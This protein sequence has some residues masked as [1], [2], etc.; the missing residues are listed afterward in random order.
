ETVAH[1]NSTINES[2]SI[3]AYNLST[4]I[5]IENVDDVNITKYWIYGGDENMNRLIVYLNATFCN[6]DESAEAAIPPE[7]VLN[8]AIISS[9]DHIVSGIGNA[10]Q[11]D[12]ILNETM[13]VKTYFAKSYPNVT[14]P[15]DLDLSDQDVIFVNHVSQ[16]AVEHINNAVHAAKGNGAYVITTEFGDALNF[17]NVNLTDHPYIDQYINNPGPEN[18]R[19]FLVYLGNRFGGFDG[20]IEQPILISNFAIYHPDSGAIFEDRDEY[21]DW[22]RNNTA[23]YRYDPG[24]PTIG[25]VFHKNHYV[26]HDLKVEDMLIRKTEEQDCNVIP[27]FCSHQYNFK[28]FFM[29]DGVTIVD[30]IIT[31]NYRMNWANFTE[32]VEDAKL[33]NVAWL[34][35]I[36]LYSTTPDEWNETVYGVP[37]SMYPYEIAQAEMDGIIEPIVISGKVTDMEGNKYYEPID[38]QVEWRVDRAIAW[39][40]L[41]RLNNSEKKIVI[42]FY[43]EGGGKANPGADID[44]YLDVPASLENLLHAMDDRGYD[45]G[46]EPLPNKTEIAK[47]I[48]GAS[49]VGTWAP[50]VL[51]ERVKS[52]NVIL[53]NKSRYLEWFGELPWE[54]QNEV[55]ERFGPPPGEIMVYENETGKYIAIPKI[56]F[57][58][59]LIVPNPTWGFLQ[60]DTTLYYDGAIPPHHEYIAYYFW[61]NREYKA[62]AMFTIFTQI[63][64]MPGKIIGLSRHDWGGILLEDMPHIHT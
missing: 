5:D 54:K 29:N 20:G 22:Y 6:G 36:N 45:L 2:A 46:N 17:S 28:D 32:G 1:I 9:S 53:I 16:P 41:H 31:C 51:E 40:K 19:R 38:Y 12:L 42:P 61:L 49:N 47:L 35:G 33:I 24:K 62:D 44:Y 63:S 3:I 8:V 39:A 14:L 4:E 21:L 25:I 60:N 55:I 58:N 7:D 15:D 59:I 11:H 30:S 23:E 56:Q 43:S 10:A 48:Q 13:N 34:Q 18:Y 50:G 26:K 27:V 37:S 52:G 64:L 57:G